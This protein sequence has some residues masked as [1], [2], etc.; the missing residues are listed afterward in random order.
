MQ[1]LFESDIKVSFDKCIFENMRKTAVELL[2]NTE[3]NQYTQ[4]ISLF[5]SKEKEYTVII[6]K[7]LTN[8]KAEEESLLERLKKIEDTE[9]YYVLCMWQDECIDIPSYAFR[10]MLCDLNSKNYKSLLFVTTRNGISVKEL[11][12]TI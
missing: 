11:S 2:R 1:T 4:C 7:A 5:S 12:K 6:K 10:K 8:E 3:K 9:I